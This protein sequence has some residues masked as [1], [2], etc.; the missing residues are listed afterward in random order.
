MKDKVV[1]IGSGFVGAT[2]AY[3]IMNWGYASEIVL[4]DIN[5]EKAVGEAMDLSHGASFLKPVKIR[6]GDYEECSD[7]SVI[8]ITAGVSQK[9]GE[10]RL[11]LVY[12]NTDIFKNIIPRIINYTK[13]SILLIVSNP[14][15]ILTYV[16]LKLSDFP[17]EQVIGSG[18]VLDTS[19]FRYMLSKYC[20][21][22][23]SNVH[24]YII[25]QHG[26]HEVP[27][28]SLTNVAG[29]SYDKY[30]N[31]C[32][33]NCNSSFKDKIYRQVRESAYEVIEKK[34]ATYYAVGLAVARIV[35]SIFRDENTILTVSTVLN[36]KYGLNN[37]ALSLPTIIGKKGIKKVLELDLADNEE[38]ALKKSAA[39]LSSIIDEL[40]L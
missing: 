34:G 10:T 33:T 3:A 4:I 9:K 29:I 18:T 11:D 1:I 40:D 36:G 23:P 15:D 2:I 13:D 16:T 8:I 19:R 25:G 37:V 12:K 14:V 24:A 32:N 35:E 6:S 17:E 21:L 20:Q 27:A 26:D 5:K 30:C 31:Y 22:N 38:K 28:W 7:A 39:V